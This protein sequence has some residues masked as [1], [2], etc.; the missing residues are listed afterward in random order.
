MARSSAR[1][2]DGWDRVD[3]REERGRGAGVGRRKSD[4]QGDAVPIDEVVL[5]AEFAAVGRFGTGLFAPLLARTLTLSRLAR[6]QSIAATSPSQ[7]KSS[8]CSRSQ[9]PTACHAQRA[10][11]RRR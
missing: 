4:H 6:L 10:P 8:L 5:G 1:T 3:F 11:G 2:D 9:I 7:F